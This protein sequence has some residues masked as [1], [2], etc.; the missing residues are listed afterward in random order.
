MEQY[1]RIHNFL[2]WYLITPIAGVVIA[3]LIGNAISPEFA[4]ISII[5]GFVTG[6][7]LAIWLSKK[8]Q[9]MF[10]LLFA[11]I[12]LI[13]M[14]GISTINSQIGSLQKVLMILG[15]VLAGIIVG[16]LLIKR[17]S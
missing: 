11:F 17:K 9:A 15:G 1:T 12:G 7:I 16:L 2:I 14:C 4:Q 5:I 3:Y 8:K 13:L 10:V 6:T